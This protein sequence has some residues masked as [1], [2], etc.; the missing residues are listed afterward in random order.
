[1]TQ[2]IATI[3]DMNKW[4]Q[5]SFNHTN[6]LHP[7]IQLS[8]N[9]LHTVLQVAFTCN[10]VRCMNLI[11]PQVDTAQLHQ[12]FLHPT[13]QQYT[14]YRLLSS[15]VEAYIDLNWLLLQL[16]Q[17]EQIEGHS[18]TEWFQLLLQEYEAALM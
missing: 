1:M 2:L 11:E 8:T 10:F 7:N 14:K 17:S 3:D 18:N 15:P 12:Q 4:V 5:L 6:T 16:L 9:Q 13:F